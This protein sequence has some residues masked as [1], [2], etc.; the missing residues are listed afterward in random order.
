MT[1]KLREGA[2]SAVR[3]ISPCEA[4]AVLLALCRDTEDQHL[5]CEIATLAEKFTQYKEEV[6]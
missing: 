3:N 6:T 2:A 4:K 1:Q 5:L